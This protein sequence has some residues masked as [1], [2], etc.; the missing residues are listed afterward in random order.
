MLAPEAGIGDN[1]EAVCCRVGLKFDCTT[2]K[3]FPSWAAPA[4]CAARSVANADCRLGLLASDRSISALSAGERYTAHHSCGM[5]RPAT[6][7]WR[8]PAAVSVDDV[9][10]T[11]SRV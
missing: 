5:S 3:N 11:G 6:K 7:R 2:G 9:V 10:A 4:C 1:D 8:A